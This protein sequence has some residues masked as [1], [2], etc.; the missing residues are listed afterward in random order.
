MLVWISESWALAHTVLLRMP[1]GTSA[2]PGSSSESTHR[3]K[4]HWSVAYVF[5]SLSNPMLP[6]CR[7]LETAAPWPAAH[8]R[9][10]G[11]HEPAKQEKWHARMA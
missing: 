3:S 11:M 1:S 2:L 4:C 10:L 8:H 5:L 6:Y 7:R 9:I